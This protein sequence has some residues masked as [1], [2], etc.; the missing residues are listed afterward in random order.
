MLRFII[1]RILMM[2]PV[3]LGVMLIVFSLSHFMPGDP[4]VNAL[5]SEYTQE[6]YDQKAA[7]MGLDKPF[8]QQFLDYLV[9][10]VFHQDLGYSYKSHREVSTEIGERI[11]ISLRL[12]IMSCMITVLL[13]IPLGIISAIKQYS[14]LD[15][16]VT[17][18]SLIFAS[19]PGFWLALMMMLLFSLTLKW[20]PSSGLSSWK[21]YV[22]PVLAQGLM[23]IAS[24]VRMTRSSMLEVIRQDYIRTARAKGLSERMVIW[25]HAL[26]NALI[27]VITVIGMQASMIIG[28]SVIIE[29]IFSIPGVGTLL[30]TAINNRDYPSTMG[31]VLVLSLFVCIVNLIVDLVY[32]TVDPRIKAQFVSSTRQRRKKE[33]RKIMGEG[34]ETA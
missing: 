2:I 3:L 13:G 16:T 18:I 21:H 24:I 32:A 29:T 26:K 15:Y 23:P 31:I 4:V 1:K 12:G 33:P 30:M 14:P 27:P 8:L 11:G 10:V 20:L 9:D 25:R 5:G 17:T 22:M 7:E 6:Q 19:M 28:G 34:A